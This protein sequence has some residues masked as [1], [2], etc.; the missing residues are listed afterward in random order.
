MAIRLS[1]VL[2][3]LILVSML[4]LG[5]SSF[6]GNMTS[7]YGINPGN[8]YND[9]FTKMT[10][11]SELANSVSQTVDNSTTSSTDVIGGLTGSTFGGVKALASQNGMIYTMGQTITTK[12]GLPPYFLVGM[13][14]ILTLLLAL[15]IIQMI[16]KP[17]FPF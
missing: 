4:F 14:S 2:I 15:A 17:F 13:I 12:I 6:V 7:S 3:S 10:E 5:I 11:T 1:A 8:E 16:W 9:T